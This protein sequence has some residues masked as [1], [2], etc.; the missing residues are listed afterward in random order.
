LHY[1]SL[2]AEQALGNFD[3]AREHQRELEK[4]TIQSIRTR[5]ATLELERVSDP[6][7]QRILREIAEPHLERAPLEQEVVEDPGP[8]KPSH[9]FLEP[10]SQ[11]PPRP[12]DEGPPPRPWNPYLS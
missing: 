11:A 3:G 1:G 2:K 6:E 7:V 9:D 10:P 4:L 5:E 12:D 8:T